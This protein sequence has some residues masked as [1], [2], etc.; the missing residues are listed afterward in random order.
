MEFVKTNLNPSGK[1]TS[2]CVVRAIVKGA[3]K[4]WL[5][6]YKDLCA[7]GEAE[8]K[9]PNSKPVYEKYLSQ[10]S[11]KKQRMPRHEDNTKYT[12]RHFAHKNSKGTFIISVANHLTVIVDGV[13]YDTW[14]CGEKCVGNYWIK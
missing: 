3:N 13:L 14:N 9:M 10:L 4:R 5:D 7:L 11:W 2:D 12:V 6:V 1:A 8:Y